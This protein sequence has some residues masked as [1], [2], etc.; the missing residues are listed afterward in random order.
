MLGVLEA[1]GA[2]SGTNSGSRVWGF[3]V[4]VQGLNGFSDLC[5]GFRQTALAMLCFPMSEALLRDVYHMAKD[6]GICI[7][8][9]YNPIMTPI[10]P[11]CNLNITPK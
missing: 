11:R 2:G 8:S 1:R 3:R 9:R 10:Y 7:L 6:S 5:K 4:Q